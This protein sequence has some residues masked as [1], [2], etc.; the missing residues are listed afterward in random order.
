M[1]GLQ[2]APFGKEHV[3]EPLVEPISEVSTGSG[4]EAD[5][6][7]EEDGRDAQAKRIKNAI[8]E[9]AP[10]LRHGR[11]AA[12]EQA[13][14]RDSEFDVS[15]SSG[16]SKPESARFADESNSFSYSDTS[17]VTQDSQD[18]RGNAPSAGRRHVAAPNVMT[19]FLSEQ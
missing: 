19:S 15:T 12:G 18:K 6:E 17:S 10:Q 4:H 1:T 14:E 5:D 13:S 8:D 16:R 9:I 11:A 2:E 7:A 3:S